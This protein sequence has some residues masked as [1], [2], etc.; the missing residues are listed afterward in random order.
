MLEKICSRCK[1]WR[2]VSDFHTKGRW[3]GTL[4]RE[5]QCKVCRS[6]TRLGKSHRSEYF[7]KYYRENLEKI[8]CRYT[9]KS[10]IRSGKIQRKECAVCGAQGEAHHDDYTKPF[11]V[12][13]LCRKHHMGIKHKKEQIVPEPRHHKNVYRTPPIR[14]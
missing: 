3:K 2:D 7:K 14:R 12:N 10:A 4:R 1:K 5:G 9:L 6:Q 11:E 8:R 13:W